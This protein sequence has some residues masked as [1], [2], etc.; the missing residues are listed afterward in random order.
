MA[1][2]KARN[3]EKSGIR[4]K[5]STGNDVL[6]AYISLLPDDYGIGILKGGLALIFDVRLLYLNIA[7]ALCM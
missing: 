6:S 3:E 2:A 1:A 7:L 5:M 4:S